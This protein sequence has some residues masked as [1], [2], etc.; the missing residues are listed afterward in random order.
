MPV[1]ML[2]PMIFFV[3]PCVFIVVLGPGALKIMHALSN[4]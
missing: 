2:F 3:F 1:K 4:L